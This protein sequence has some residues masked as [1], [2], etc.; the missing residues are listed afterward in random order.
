VIKETTGTNQAGA[1]TVVAPAHWTSTPLAPCP[2]WCTN[3]DDRREHDSD[4]NSCL[5]EG[6]VDTMPAYFELLA[7]GRVRVALQRYEWA[8]W[9]T[10]S[11]AS[12]GDVLAV[13]KAPDP[14][15]PNDFDPA[16]TFRTAADVRNFA[17]MLLAGADEWD[18]EA[19]R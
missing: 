19:Q 18:A 12:Q 5:H 7:P 14:D 17:M 13:L 11:L 10:R 3:Q 6:V 9:K 4:N 1:T 15:E 8:E 2:S 16:F